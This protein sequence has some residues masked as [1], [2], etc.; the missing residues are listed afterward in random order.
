M[1]CALATVKYE[2]N[3]VG[4]LTADGTV[5]QLAGGLVANNNAKAVPL[6]THTVTVTGEVYEKAGM[7]MISADDAQLVGVI[8]QPD[9]GRLLVRMHSSSE[10]RVLTS[11]CELRSLRPCGQP[12]MSQF[13]L[14]YILNGP[15]PH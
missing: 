1:L 2:R 14:M 7:T 6:L 12:S 5:Y 4:L 15:V 13:E 10:V 3:P 9:A 11:M 8:Q